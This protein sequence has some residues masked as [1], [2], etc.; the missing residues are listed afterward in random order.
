MTLHSDFQDTD[1]KYDPTPMLC[2][3]CEQ[4][5]RQWGFYTAQNEED[6]E[7]CSICGS[8]DVAVRPAP[9]ESKDSESH[10]DFVD[11]AGDP[12]PRLYP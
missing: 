4:S 5:A 7:F 10:S 8:E 9:E 3:S 1:Y 2:Y 6:E 11:S 12:R